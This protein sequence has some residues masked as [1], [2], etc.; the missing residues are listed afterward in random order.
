[1]EVASEVLHKE[2]NDFIARDHE[3]VKFAAKEGCKDD[4]VSAALVITRMVQVISRYETELADNVKDSLED[5]FR[6]PLPIITYINR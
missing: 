5:D 1:M 6:K 3:S 4:V 2:L